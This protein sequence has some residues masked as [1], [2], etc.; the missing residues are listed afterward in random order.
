MVEPLESSSGKSSRVS[1]APVAMGTKMQIH[2][3]SLSG[4]IAVILSHSSRAVAEKYR[5]TEGDT[6]DAFLMALK[7][8]ALGCDSISPNDKKTNFS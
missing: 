6:L 3:I 1:S 7:K 8:G 5:W 4:K 2:K